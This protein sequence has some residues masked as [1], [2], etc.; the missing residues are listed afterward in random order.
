MRANL[1]KGLG[2]TAL[3]TAFAFN[4]AAAADVPP[5]TTVPPPSVVVTPAAGGFDW[6]GPYFGLVTGAEFEIGFGYLNAIAGVQ[7]G[8]NFVAGGFLFGV[9]GQALL[10]MIG[11]DPGLPR[12]EFNANLR[13]GALLGDSAL[14]YAEGGGLLQVGLGGLLLTAGG[15]VEFAVSQ[16]ATIFG[17]AKA[18]FEPG[19]GF[20][21]TQFQAGVNFHIG[22]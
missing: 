12:G 18:V 8:Y 21:G 9:E 13:A 19:F 15:G 3:A 11:A 5:I 20:L 14:L 2:L 7:A 22:Q 4:S 1:L 10:Q 16:A 6:S 17:E